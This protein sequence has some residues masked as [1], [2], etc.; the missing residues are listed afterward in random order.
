MKDEECRKKMRT[1]ICKM[2]CRTLNWSEGLPLR[3]VGSPD[4]GKCLGW[5]WVDGLILG[6]AQRVFIADQGL[7][8][9]FERFAHE[10]GDSKT[11]TLAINSVMS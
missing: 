6:N 1:A 5:H 2:C 8:M 9:K 7:S 11:E 4:T 10:L 3:L